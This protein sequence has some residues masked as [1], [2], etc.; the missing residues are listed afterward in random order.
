MIKPLFISPEY[1]TN[2]VNAVIKKIF[3]DNMDRDVFYPI[4]LSSNDVLVDKGLNIHYPIIESI[5][6]QEIKYYTY[7]LS[8]DAYFYSWGL[9]AIWGFLNTKRYK[10]I[11][12]IHS[13]SGPYSSHLV[14]AILKKLTGKPWIA[15]F[16]EPWEDNP[17]MSIR[18]NF[19]YKIILKKWELYCAKYA[20]LIIHDNQIIKNDWI[21]KYGNIVKDKI[22]VLNLPFDP[23]TIGAVHNREKNY[24]IIFSHIGNLYGQRNAQTLVKA[25]FELCEDFPDLRDKFRIEFIGN[26]EKEDKSLIEAFKLQDVIILHGKKS[27]SECIEYYNNS[28]VFLVIEGGCQ[29]NLFFPSKIIK[30]FYFGRPIIG[31]TNEGSTL[32]TELFNSGNISVSTN[33][34]LGIKNALAKMI[35]SKGEDA[36]SNTNY[37]RRFSVD[38]V[39]TD[40]C[41]I[42]KS[43]KLYE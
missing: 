11:S 18:K 41:R 3:V 6:K 14:A 9:R 10:E 30:Y 34:V 15:H 28:D 4:V 12:Y 36:T 39:L 1:G 35:K 17:Y 19:I 43:V 40:Y 37:W 20:D 25:V 2:D 7:M 32:D 31:L 8:P 13:I 38:N 16:F 42:L 21:R 29:G 23:K 26:V 22:F 24:P 33:D 27:E 5:K